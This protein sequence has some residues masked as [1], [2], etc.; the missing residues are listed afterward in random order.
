MDDQSF[1]ISNRPTRILRASL[2]KAEGDCVVS[3]SSIQAIESSDCDWECK[4][5]LITG[6]D[7]IRVA[8]IVKKLM[9]ESQ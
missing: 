3:L 7:L 1:V 6:S 5:I 9:G 8:E 2:R 4:S